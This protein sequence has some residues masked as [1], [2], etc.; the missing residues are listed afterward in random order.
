MGSTS[1]GFGICRV[2]EGPTQPGFGRCYCC[3]TLV[4][5]LQMPLAPVTAVTPYRV[6]D[7]MHRLL[8]GY[9]DASEA[10][11]RSA[12]VD[13]LAGLFGR[14]LGDQRSRLLAR[15]GGRW[16]VV[17]GVPSSHRP[18]V[19]VDA[20]LRAVPALART[21]RPLLVRGSEP[22][23]HLVASRRGFEVTPGLGGGSTGDRAL[24]VDDSFTTGARAQSAVAALR[25]AG[26]RVA[27]VLVV[28][29]VVA[30]DSA[31]WQAAYWDSTAGL[32]RDFRADPRAAIHRS[33]G[34]ILA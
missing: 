30:P 3:S 23:D 14:W 17:V 31:S 5:R 20:L 27:G 11:V 21:H 15:T 22:T 4:A 6:G 13:R 8:R 28:G 34:G 24:V 1:V 25:A 32:R 9:K 33:G 2:C 18:G 26:I 10:E 29:R 7:E 12:S 19:P 16:D